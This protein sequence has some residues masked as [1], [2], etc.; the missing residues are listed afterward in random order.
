MGITWAVTTLISTINIMSAAVATPESFEHAKELLAEG[1]RDLLVHAI[2]GAVSNCSKACEIMAKHKGEMAAEC[3]EAYFYYGK[4]L[5]ELSRVESGVLGNALDGVDMETK[6]T[7]VKDALVEDTEAMTTDEKSEIEEKVADAL[8]ENFEKHDVVARAHTGDNTE[9]D[10]V[11]EGDQDGD[12]MDTDAEK[13][14]AEAGNLEQAWQMFDLAKV[15]YGKAGDVAKECEA[16][17]FLGEVSLENSNFEQA[18]EDLTVC[19]AKRIKA[20][21]ADSRAIAET[22]YQLGV[23]QAHCAE[24]ANAEKSLA[25]AVAVLNSRIANLKK[26]DTSDNITKELAELTLLCTEIKERTADHKEMQKGT[27]KEENDFVSIFK[28]AE[29]HEIGTKKAVATA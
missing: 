23:A 17:T 26:M 9:D 16:L 7:D 28:G 15:I 4:A 2:P 21:P 18:V 1:K 27:Y 14:E 6:P 11:M 25:A 3:A 8:E 19:L 12:Q 29:V 24:Y 13:V 10:E 20:M 22:H 5:L